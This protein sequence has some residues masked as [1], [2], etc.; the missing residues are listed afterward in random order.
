MTA[1]A[2]IPLM[3]ATAPDAAA[4]QPD[5]GQPTSLIDIPIEPNNKLTIERRGQVALIGI[6]RPYIQNGIDPETFQALAKAYYDYD[7]APSLRAAV[8]FG[9]GEH[10]SRGIDVDGF[11]AVVRTGKPLIGRSGV[12]DP[13]AKR[14]PHLTKPLIVAVHGDTWN[15]ADELLLVADIR[16]A[17][18]ALTL[19]RHFCDHHTARTGPSCSSRIRFV[20]VTSSARE[21]RAS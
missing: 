5:P 20:A 18:G 17:G 2:M 4:G 12:I 3:A 21:V 15:M 8:L 16:V 1:A 19:W 9:H 11:K 6:N 13:L 14:K 10:F 7:H